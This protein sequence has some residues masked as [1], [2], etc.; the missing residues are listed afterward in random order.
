MYL[1]FTAHFKQLYDAFHDLHSAFHGIFEI[2]ITH[3]YIYVTHVLIYT[4]IFV[5]GKS[6]MTHPLTKMHT[7]I[8]LNTFVSFL[9][10]FN[11]ADGLLMVTNAVNIV[12]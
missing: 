8:S 1:A 11:I 5:C 7:K 4:V 2:E 3:T 9:Y 6:P 10:Y 12:N